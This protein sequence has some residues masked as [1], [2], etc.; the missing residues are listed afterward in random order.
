M[1][2]YIQKKES[3]EDQLEAVAGGGAVS[4]EDV[5]NVKGNGGICMRCGGKIIKKR[6]EELGIERDVLACESCSS[7]L[8]YLDVLTSLPRSQ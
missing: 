8:R 4:W 2:E 6:V 5:V 1:S 7:I 3:P